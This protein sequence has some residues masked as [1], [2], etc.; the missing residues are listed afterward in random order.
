M[1]K[2]CFNRKT[3]LEDANE[4]QASLLIEIMNFKKISA[5]KIFKKECK[6]KKQFEEHINFSKL[7]KRFMIALIRKY[8]SINT[9]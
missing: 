9:N 1:L 8:I 3:T 5:P 2:K 4:D 7:E 6:N